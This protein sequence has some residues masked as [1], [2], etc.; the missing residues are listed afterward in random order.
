MKGLFG[1]D[2]L[3]LKLQDRGRRSSLNGFVAG[4]LSG[5]GEWRRRRIGEGR[6]VRLL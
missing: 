3:D 6:S 1:N 4:F 2:R 5:F